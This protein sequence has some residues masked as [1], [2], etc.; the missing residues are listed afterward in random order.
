MYNLLIKQYDKD[1]AWENN[2]VDVYL[3]DRLFEYTDQTI[4]KTMKIDGRTFE[5]IIRSHYDGELSTT[6][7]FLIEPLPCAYQ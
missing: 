5:E 1:R 7:R 6:P 3:I 4:K 2:N